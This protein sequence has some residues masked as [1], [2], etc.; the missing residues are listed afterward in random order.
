[1]S[2][3][4]LVSLSF[5]LDLLLKSNL[6]CFYCKQPV[7][8]WYEFA[9]EPKQWSLERIDN[10]FGHNHDNVEVACLSC[11]LKRRC[12]YHERYLYTKQLVITKM[13]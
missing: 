2:S 8:L 9:R 5:V 12:M 6:S 10:S 3:G 4:L 11:N 13:N 7:L 1:M